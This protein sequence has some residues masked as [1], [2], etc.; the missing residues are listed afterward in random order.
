[1]E[2]MLQMH[3][4]NPQLQAEYKAGSLAPP[5]P[6]VGND[7]ADEPPERIRLSDIIPGEIYLGKYR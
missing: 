4:L 3:P 7:E 5:A 1:M 6:E 2:H